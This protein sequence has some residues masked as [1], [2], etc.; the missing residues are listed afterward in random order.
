M[1]R[2]TSTYEEKKRHKKV[3]KFTVQLTSVEPTQVCPD[4]Q[5]GEAPLMNIHNSEILD[6]FIAVKRIHDSG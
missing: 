2:R 3:R 1:T 6:V 4:T 5:C